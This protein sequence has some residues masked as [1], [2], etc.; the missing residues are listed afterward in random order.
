VV[1]LVT[2]V[3]TLLFN[4]DMGLGASITFAVLTVIFRTQL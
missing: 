2:W 3:S 4:L 1:W